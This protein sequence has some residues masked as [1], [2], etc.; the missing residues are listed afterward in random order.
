MCAGITSLIHLSGMPRQHFSRLGP[1]AVGYPLFEV[2][3]SGMNSAGAGQGERS[4]Y[5]TTP[6]NYQQDHFGMMVI[7]WSVGAPVLHLQIR[8]ASGA[9]VLEEQVPLSQKSGDEY[10]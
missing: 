9:V 8:D 3:A 2:I 1:E 4:R 7:D 10:P 6:D 5:R